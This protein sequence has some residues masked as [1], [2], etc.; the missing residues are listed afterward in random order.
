MNFTILIL[1]LNIFLL[2]FI[3]GGFWG[4][5]WLP[6]KRRDYD[7]IADL[8]D[9]KPGMIFYDLGSGTGRL[10]FYLAKKYKIQ[11]VGIEISPVLY[12]YSKIKSLF[13]QEVEIKYGN[14]FKHDL[15]KADVICVFLHPKMYDSL[16]K[17]IR[18]E[19][20]KESTILILSTWPFKNA[21]P[22]EINQ[23]DK[24][25]TYYLYKKAN[26]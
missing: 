15:S 10:L 18:R 14:L 12:L 4:A 16:K 13:F 11:C 5:I 1:F 2:L 8:A 21:S 17:K 22:L 19:M 3:L 26:L 9:L 7:R 25:T 6:T 23:K 20:K 24:E